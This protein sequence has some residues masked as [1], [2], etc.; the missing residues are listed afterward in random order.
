VDF[1]VINQIVIRF[2]GFVRYWKKNN[3]STTRQY[4]T[5]S[6]FRK[7]YDSVGRKILYN[8]VKEFGQPMKLV[9]LIKICLNE[10]YNKVRIEKHV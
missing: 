10:M 3:V 1:D 5:Y 6:D 2:L 9:R 4:S 7:T 8:I